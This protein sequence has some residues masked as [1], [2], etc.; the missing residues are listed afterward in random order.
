MLLKLKFS[1]LI[2]VNALNGEKW[3]LCIVSVYYFVRIH[4]TWTELLRYW[5][6]ICLV[7]GPVKKPPVLPTH[8]HQT[9]TPNHPLHAPPSQRYDSG[10]RTEETRGSLNKTSVTVS[11][12]MTSGRNMTAVNMNFFGF[13]YDIYTWGQQDLHWQYGQ[14]WEN[15]EFLCTKKGRISHVRDMFY[16]SHSFYLRVSC[17]YL[18]SV[19]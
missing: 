4:N 16:M 10:W 8:R 12:V 7:T 6:F 15:G 5:Q 3:L 19:L 1:K 9:G 18:F 2:K 11:H 14:F 17:P 13:R